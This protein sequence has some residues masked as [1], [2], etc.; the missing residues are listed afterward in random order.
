MAYATVAYH[1][2]GTYT[3]HAF[4]AAKAARS[5]T[6]MITAREGD[7]GKTSRRLLHHQA[8]NS[9]TVL[10]EPAASANARSVMPGKKVSRQFDEERQS[11]NARSRTPLADR[12]PDPARSIRQL[13]GF[14]GHSAD[15]EPLAARRPK[16]PFACRYRFA[17]NVGFGENRA[18]L[19][20]AKTSPSQA[21]PHHIADAKAVTRKAQSFN[22][23]QSASLPPRTAI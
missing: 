23:R 1:R 17:A 13:P 2:A 21:V 18:A 5:E 20:I 8:S 14:N 11:L 10:W 3:I 12:D 16:R 22:D 4:I 7:A 15:T 9:M 6:D 19:S